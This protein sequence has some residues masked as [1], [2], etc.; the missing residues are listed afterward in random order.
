M[1][2]GSRA[3]GVRFV[4]W[5]LLLVGAAAG[6][7]TPDPPSGDAALPHVDAVTASDKQR[8]SIRAFF[9]RLDTDGDGQIEPDEL[10]AYVRGSVGGREF[11]DPLEIAAATKATQELIDGT[12]KGE[13]ISEEEL[14]THITRSSGR[15]LTPTR[16]ARWVQFGL[17][18]P[19]YAE[20]FSQNAITALDFP[21]LLADHGATLKE[22]LG[23]KS[24]LHRGK[25]SR[26]LKLQVR[27]GAFLPIRHA[28]RFCRPSLSAILV[29]TLPVTRP[30]TFTGVLAIV[31]NPYSPTRD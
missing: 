24:V 27:L 20:A 12:D 19:Q 22:D 4:L 16:V 23:I 15:L 9:R 1:R 7:R 10:S 8:F 21:F 5:A 17:S 3:R 13:T 18:L 11:D 29:A 30:V 25:I 6:K 2:G 31:T 14:L 26:A 28:A